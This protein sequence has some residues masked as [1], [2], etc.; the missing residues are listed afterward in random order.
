MSETRQRTTWLRLAPVLL[1]FLLLVGTGLRGLD[2]GLHWDE[3]PWQIGPTKHMVE[4]ETLLPGY[5]TY[6]SFDYWLNLAVLLPDVAHPREPGERLNAYLVR[7]LDSPAYLYRLRT[8]YLAITSL[9]LLW[10]YLLVLQRGGRWGEA[11]FASCVLGGSW[12]VAYHLRWVASDGMLMQFAAL[13]VLFALRALHTRRPSWL[14]AAV[15]TAALGSGTKYPGGLLLLPVALAAIFSLVGCSSKT[16]SKR[17]ITL[18][19]LFA[20]VSLAVT[21]ALV[22][23]PHKVAQAM[24]YEMHHYATGHGGHTVDRGLDHAGRIL[25]YLSTV[26]LSSHLVIAIA[27][28]LLAIIGIGHEFARDRHT[29][30]VLF[31]FPFAYCLYFSAQGTMVVRNLLVLAPFLALAA[32]RGAVVVATFLATRIGSPGG[33]HARANYARV[34]WVLLLGGVVCFNA[35]WLISSAESIVARHTDRFAREAAAY[36]RMRPD[37]RYL[38]SPRVTLDL[39]RVAPPLS[40]VTGTAADADAFVLYAR[41]GMRHWRDWPANR[42]DLTSAWFGPREVNFNMYPNWWGDDRIVVI[43]TLRAREIGLRIA[44]ISEDATS[45]DEPASLARGIHSVA[46]YPQI[47]ADSLP[48]SWAL[49]AVDPRSLVPPAMARSVVGPLARGPSSGG[50]DLDGL[51]CTVLGENGTVVSVTVIST[52]AFDLERHEPSS[53]VVSGVGV[54]AY[55]ASPAGRPDVRLFARTMNSAVIVHVTG[56]AEPRAFREDLATTLAA[57]A[58]AR[59]DAAQAATNPRR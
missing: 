51:S 44:G 24:L 29:A 1:P 32:A 2:F 27:L 12:E 54:S 16:K 8:V 58:L 35:A 20:G 36:V 56:A 19:V 30:L 9:A 57:I 46:P 22:F 41:E 40:N 3:R 13:A 28:F 59:L 38:L 42:R 14:L 7:T 31:V 47:P 34:A 48:R 5:Y 49:P 45:A 10:V 18:A 6:P 37:S 26:L 52:G 53:V 11:L 23:E 55:L 50:W 21:P 4:S 43:D 15:I 25:A 33:G 17:L 39:A